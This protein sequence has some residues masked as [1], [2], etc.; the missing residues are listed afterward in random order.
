MITASHQPSGSSQLPLLNILHFSLYEL[1]PNPQCKAQSWCSLLQEFLSSGLKHPWLHN[2]LYYIPFRSHCYIWV[3]PSSPGY[4]EHLKRV[5]S[6]PSPVWAHLRHWT[7]LPDGGCVQKGQYLLQYKLIKCLKDLCS[8]FPASFSSPHP[9]TEPSPANWDFCLQTAST[10]VHIK[11][12]NKRF[13]NT[14][15]LI[16]PPPL[17]TLQSSS[18][19]PCL[20]KRCS[21]FLGNDE[22]TSHKRKEKIHQIQKAFLENK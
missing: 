16:S 13:H 5:E 12:S 14:P 17:F 11:V 9:T 20:N 6:P 19:A 3:G 10:P 7:N 21:M 2:L 22:A 8:W 15:I 4:H 1:K 18:R